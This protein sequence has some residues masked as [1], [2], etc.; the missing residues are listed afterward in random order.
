[1]PAAL[2]EDQRRAVL[3]TLLEGLTFE[4]AA[5]LEGVSKSTA[6]GVWRDF[7]EGRLPGL[8]HLVDHAE[9][10]R[11]TA[12]RLS[13][14]SNSPMEA[15]LG[16][17]ALERLAGLGVAPDQLV[18]FVDLGQKLAEDPADAPLL[19][20]AAMKLRDLEQETGLTFRE[21][22]EEAKTLHQRSETLRPIVDQLDAQRQAVDGLQVTEQVLSHT[23]SSLGTKRTELKQNVRQLQ[24]RE[25]QIARRVHDLEERAHDAEERLA[26]ARQATQ[27]LAALGMGAG[28]IPGFAQRLGA[29][30]QRHGWEVG[31]VRGRLLEELEHLDGSLTLHAQV[32]ELREQSERLGDER[33][34]R[35]AQ[36]AK[37]RKERQRLEGQLI[38]MRE[39]I[40][41]ELESVAATLAEATRQAG[42]ELLDQ[43]QHYQ[44]QVMD[45]AT[46]VGR[47]EAAVRTHDWLE[48]LLALFT[49][50]GEAQPSQVRMLALLTFGS[51]R[52]WCLSQPSDAPLFTANRLH[53]LIA[54]FEEWRP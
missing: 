14:S 11:E 16:L 32:V 21:L 25:E 49:G 6:H 47:L 51:F 37:L 41:K 50:Q 19:V 52:R 28:D 45:L 23:V 48:P 40:T 4:E 22:V 39:T 43:S 30:A 35:Q 1:M 8:E 5:I 29:I 20:Q 24:R 42:Q 18:A 34:Q 31:D 13:Q 9:L 2:T 26:I 38:V 17:L 15:H 27:D 3:W 10:L 54:S 46:E 7:A 36:V 53:D 12:I 44:D 33:A